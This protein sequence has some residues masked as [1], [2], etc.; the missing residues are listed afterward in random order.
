MSL[1]SL[2]EIAF[3]PT[4]F[5]DGN[6]RLFWAGGELYRGI[7]EK[8]AAFTRQLFA[9]GIVRELIEKKL[10][11]ATELTEF[12]WPGYP[13]VLHHERVSFVSYAYEWSPL[14]L[15]EAGLCVVRFLRELTR[16]RLAMA[17][18]ASWNVLF[19]A[20]APVY[21]DFADIIAAPENPEVYWGVLAP[22][23]HSYYIR[24]L[25]LHAR[26]QGNLARLL[27]TDYEHDPVQR[28]FTEAT[29]SRGLGA[30]L[31]RFWRRGSASLRNHGVGGDRSGYFSSRLNHFENQLLQFRFPSQTMGRGAREGHPVIARFLAESAPETALVIGGDDDLITL[32][33]KSGATTVAIDRNPAR[34]DAIYEKARTESANILPLV[35]DLRY[36]APG[37]GVQNAVLAPAL[38]RLQ[39][40]AVIA[41]ELIESL[42]F[43]QRLQFDQ[44][45]GTLSALSLR[46]LWVDFPL[47]ESESVRGFLRD[48]YFEW[49]SRERFLGALAAHFDS[50]RVEESPD[51]ASSLILCEKRPA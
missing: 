37:Y 15:R 12:S 40:E 26:G 27:L 33:A 3:H 18:V 17:G 41:L 29:R 7:P 4:S 10:I 47:L 35:V 32:V 44:I 42:V 19:A 39:C 11:P 50:V 14:M 21:V 45:A 5:C 8:C 36:P 20:T 30:T 22:H 24:P 34:V 48:P 51:G 38:E 2:G 16:H 43:K 46:Y 49:F 28:E 6:G 13:L 1:Q 9:D 23:L 31:D 25:E